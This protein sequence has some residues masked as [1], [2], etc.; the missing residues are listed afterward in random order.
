MGARTYS[1]G[2][3]ERQVCGRGAL[4]TASNHTNDAFTDE[5]DGADRAG[6]ERGR[7]VGLY[8]SAAGP[9]RNAVCRKNLPVLQNWLRC[10][11]LTAACV[12]AGCI[13]AA[14]AAHPVAAQGRLEANYTATFAGLPIGRGTWVVEIYDDQFTAAA[15]GV[16]SGLLRLFTSGQG[17]GASR[18]LIQAGQ[19]VPTSYAANIT[20]DRKVDEVRLVLSGGNVKEYAVEPPLPPHSERIPVTDAHRQG[21][22]DPMTSTLN[23]VPGAGDPRSPEACNRRVAIFDGRLRYDLHS[24]YKRMENV[25]AEKG[26][27]GPV[28]VCAVYFNPIA[29]YVPDRPAIKYLIELR[30]AEVWLAPIAGTRVLV[31][32]RFSVPTPFGMGVLQATQFIS[33]PLPA[34]AS[35]ASAKTQ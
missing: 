24:A 17:T 9:K 27:Q 30:D 20:Y 26:Y 29:G 22:M 16:T 25:K 12:A 32:F 35:A 5:T 28:V 4:A 10:R 21:V 23:R 11:M 15:S 1:E 6:K 14:D 19:P 3:Q 18:G 2:L 8:S 7:Q 33:V 34:R 31:P 13:V